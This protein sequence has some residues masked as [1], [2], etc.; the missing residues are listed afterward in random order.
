MIL[1][2]YFSP[3]EIYGLKGVTERIIKYRQEQQKRAQKFIKLD[4]FN[5]REY[6]PRS[7]YTK[8][9]HYFQIKM[10]RDLQKKYDN[11]LDQISTNDFSIT[12]NELEDAWNLIFVA[13]KK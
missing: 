9:Y 11:E 12:K 6:I 3:I 8:I 10:R 5:L 2:P 13:T 7:I 1:K 4:P